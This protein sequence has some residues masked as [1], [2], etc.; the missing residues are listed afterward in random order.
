MIRVIAGK[1]R[2][3]VLDGPKNNDIRPTMDRA[4]EGL[5]NIINMNIEGSSFLELFAGSGSV[6]IEAISRGCDSNNTVLVDASQESIKLINTNL[7]KIEETPQVVKS[8]V[9]S[10]LNRETKKF[11]YI[12]M[13]PPY[14]MNIDEIEK[15]IDAIVDN[16]LLSENG[17]II[18]EFNT[19]KGIEFNKVSL[20]KFKKYGISGFS[21]Y[22]N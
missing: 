10:Y 18:F 14:D 16:S 3:L 7:A 15:I 19:K 22:E 4:K 1:Y 20:V 9:L 5:F 6:S 17:Q 13:D 21:F 12:F 8:D 2:R 11:D